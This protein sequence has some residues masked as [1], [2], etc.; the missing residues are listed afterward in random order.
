MPLA[1][2]PNRGA[3]SAPQ[4]PHFGGSPG[5]PK[6]GPPGGPPGRGKFP[7]EIFRAGP[8]RAG[9][10]APGGRPGGPPGGPIWGPFWGPFWTPF[11]DHILLFLYYWGGIWGGP[12]RAPFWTPPGGPPGRPGGVQKSA[13]FF[14]YLITLPVG[15]VL[16]HFFCPPFFGTPEQPPQD[17]PPGPPLYRGTPQPWGLCPPKGTPPLGGYLPDPP[18]SPPW[19]SSYRGCGQQMRSLL[20]LSDGH[21]R[22]N[23]FVPHSAIEVA[24]NK[25]IALIGVGAVRENGWDGSPL[26][27]FS[28]MGGT[29]PFGRAPPSKQG[30]EDPRSEPRM[31]KGRPFA[32]AKRGPTW[33]VRLGANVRL[34]TKASAAERPG[35]GNRPVRAQPLLSVD[36]SHWGR[37]P[38]GRPP[39]AT[40]PKAIVTPLL[41][42]APTSTQ[43]SNFVLFFPSD[44]PGEAP[45]ERPGRRV[46]VGGRWLGSQAL[47]AQ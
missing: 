24:V 7:R 32:R 8:G 25:C 6:K 28:A 5:P 27:L 31:R 35:Q 41:A 15:T 33:S 42:L 11:G 39:T 2:G 1:L 3:Q 44:S 26:R 13:H 40:L 43:N 14:G 21:C 36:L 18:C 45:R 19:S 12:R 38:A 47:I 23:A 9:R 30:S 10:A 29:H 37:R 16:G 46:R 17:T 4:T 20:S 34:Q 22:T